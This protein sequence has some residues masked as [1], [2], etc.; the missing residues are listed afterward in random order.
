MRGKNAG[1]HLYIVGVSDSVFLPVLPPM[2][3]KTLLASPS[4]M[5]ENFQVA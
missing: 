4:D 1:H 2:T 3:M 5:E